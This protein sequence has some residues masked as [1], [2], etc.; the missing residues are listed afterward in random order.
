MNSMRHGNT[1]KMN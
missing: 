1:F